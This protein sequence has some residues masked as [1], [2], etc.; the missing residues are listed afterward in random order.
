MKP[1]GE[2]SC[3]WLCAGPGP[4]PG[5]KAIQVAHEGAHV[6]AGIL[7]AGTHCSGQRVDHDQRVGL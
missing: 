2:P 3:P 4:G 5:P 6:R 1:V 7:V